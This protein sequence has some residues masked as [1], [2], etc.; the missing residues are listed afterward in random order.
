[1]MVATVLNPA[2]A[3]S[4]RHK[5][6]L[7]VFIRCRDWRGGLFSGEIRYSGRTDDGDKLVKANGLDGSLYDCGDFARFRRGRRIG[8]L[9]CHAALLPA[10][11]P[12]L[13]QWRR[14]CLSRSLW[15]RP[16]NSWRLS[17]M[18]RS[19]QRLRC[20][21]RNGGVRG[22]RWGPGYSGAQATLR[23][24][25]CCGV[26]VALGITDNATPTLPGTPWWR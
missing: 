9:A 24:C 21:W 26:P 23:F 11:W 18:T 16:D 19:F 7:S 22:F 10:R 12:T 5:L 8:R 4:A 1:M 3:V 6:L 17:A 2:G 20:P 14:T 15:R 25:W 13:A